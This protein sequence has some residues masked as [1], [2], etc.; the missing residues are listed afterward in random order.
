MTAQKTENGASETPS[1]SDTQPG[2]SGPQSGNE[3]QEQPEGL[4]GVE[5]IRHALRTMPYAPGVYRMLGARGE[6]LYVGKALSLRKRVTSY[7]HVARL[8][9]R[10]RRMVSET[11]TMEIVTTHTEA[12]ALLLEANYIKRMKPRFNI[13][14]RDDKS[15]PWLMLTDEHPFPQIAKHR[16]KAVKGA[17]LWGPFA[18]AW[19]VNQTLNLIQR[20]FLLR[21]CTDAVFNSRSRPCLLYQIKRCSAPCVDRIA[22]QDYALL[23]EQARDFLSGK[24]GAA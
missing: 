4:K 20:V 8:P 14:L 6:V 17:S 19:A 2:G 12:E 9:E 18:S 3:I 15:Y 5:A 11:V 24:D 1:V 16:G 22:P 21:S 7:T 10:L 23:V 13:L